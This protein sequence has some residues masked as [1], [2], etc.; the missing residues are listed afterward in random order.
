[1]LLGEKHSNARYQSNPTLISLKCPCQASDPELALQLERK[2]ANMRIARTDSSLEND[3]EQLV[4]D[5]MGSGVQ[6]KG[7]KG[8]NLMH[9]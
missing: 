5:L 9:N 3:I 4:R 1:M 2:M 8:E 7:V 6:L